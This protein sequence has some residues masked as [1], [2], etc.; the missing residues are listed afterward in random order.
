MTAL[1]WVGTAMAGLG[2][3][4]F[5]ILLITHDPPSGYNMGTGD[6]FVPMA[7]AGAFGIIGIIICFL[8]A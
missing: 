4:V 7:L 3:F 5:G 1:Q 6:S 8:G 2:V